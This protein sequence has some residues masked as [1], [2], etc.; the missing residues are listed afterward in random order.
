MTLCDIGDVL[1]SDPSAVILFNLSVLPL[2]LSALVAYGL[3][4]R[5]VRKNIQSK[6]IM[7]NFKFYFKF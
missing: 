4:W 2:E 3:V 6:T 1:A 7:E 5:R